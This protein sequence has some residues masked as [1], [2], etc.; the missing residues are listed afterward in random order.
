MPI[1]DDETQKKV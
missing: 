1:S